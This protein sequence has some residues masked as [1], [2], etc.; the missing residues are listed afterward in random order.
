MMKILRETKRM[1]FVETKD[2]RRI[3]LLKQF[4]KRMIKRLK[5]KEKNNF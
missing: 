2:G 3:I 1:Y 5:R 4:H